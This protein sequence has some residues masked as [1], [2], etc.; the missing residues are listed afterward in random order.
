VV[1]EGKVYS[2]SPSYDCTDAS[3][4]LKIIAILRKFKEILETELLD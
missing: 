3:D 2:V 1:M 4:L